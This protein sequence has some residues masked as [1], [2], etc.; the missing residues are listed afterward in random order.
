MI[1][2]GDTVCFKRTPTM[3]VGR[4]VTLVKATGIGPD[5]VAYHAGSAIIRLPNGSYIQVHQSWLMKMVWTRP[6]LQ[7][8]PH[9]TS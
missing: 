1:K 2:L 7:G 3:P 9:A 8:I 6:I 4:V 5:G